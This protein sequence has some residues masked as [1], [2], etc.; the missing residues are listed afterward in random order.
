MKDPQGLGES[1]FPEN[2]PTLRFLDTRYNRAATWSCAK[3]DGGKTH[4]AKDNHNCVLF[5]LSDDP[6]FMYSLKVRQG[7]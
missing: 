5:D 3:M 7:L 6:G 1:P 2:R 4:G